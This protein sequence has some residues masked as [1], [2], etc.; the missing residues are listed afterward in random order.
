L[1]DTVTGLGLK[2]ISHAHKFTK[3]NVLM[4]FGL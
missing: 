4:N 3:R 1:L 2:N